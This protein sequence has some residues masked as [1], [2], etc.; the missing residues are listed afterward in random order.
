MKHFNLILSTLFLT[1]LVLVGCKDEEK[2]NRLYPE[3]PAEPF[4]MTDCHGTLRYEEETDRWYVTTRHIPGGGY[5]VGPEESASLYINNMS[6][7]YKSLED[8][9]V[10]VSGTV[11]FQYREFGLGYDQTISLQVYTM[12]VK[13]MERDDTVY[14]RAEDTAQHWCGTVSTE[15]PTWYYRI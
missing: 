10:V 12:D 9:P 5:A 13:E 14:T 6:E 2:T 11:T 3:E 1:L 4:E 8:A 15:S 7:A